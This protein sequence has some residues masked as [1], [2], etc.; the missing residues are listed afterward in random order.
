M[1]V[2]GSATFNQLGG[3]FRNGLPLPVP[4]RHRIIEMYE[5]GM[6]PCEISRQLRISH[7]CVS[8][9]V[10][11][12]NETGSFHPGPAKIKTTQD[13]SSQVRTKIEE[14]QKA[15][16]GIFSWEVRDSLLADGFCTKQ[17][18]PTVPV[19]SRLLRKTTTPASRE[20][21]RYRETEGEQDEVMDGG[22]TFYPKQSTTT[23]FE[24]PDEN[25][26]GETSKEKPASL[27]LVQRGMY[28]SF[29]PPCSTQTQTRD[30][31]LLF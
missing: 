29:F 27:S 6:R 17:S 26:L 9:L 31:L 19:I 28:I 23:S 7:G 2:Q 5:L 25:V 18:L 24:K 8:K 16:P 13:V 3:F 30:L 14:Y 20:N 12:Y 15:S 21:G 10:A 1:L 22:F 4:V 11:K